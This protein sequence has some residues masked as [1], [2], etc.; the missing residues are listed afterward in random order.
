MYTFKNKSLLKL[1]L[2]R[3]SYA[4]EKGV[5][6]NERLEFLGDS[7]LGYVI[8][9]NLFDYGYDE[10]GM[11]QV[12]KSIVC[13]KNLVKAFDRL[14][15]NN[16]IMKKLLVG[17]AD[18]N[19]DYMNNDKIKEDTFEAII[20]AIALDCNYDYDILNEF[21]SRSVKPNYI[22]EVKHDYSDIISEYKH[23]VCSNNAC[24]LL[25]ELKQKGVINAFDY[26]MFI[27]K[28]DHNGNPIWSG[29]LMIEYDNKIITVKETNQDSKKFLKQLLSLSGIMSL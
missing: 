22:Y 4:N 23:N 1:A 28:Y 12:R 18:Y 25:Q 20:G 2:T 3:S 16:V 6:S 24:N 14:N 29:E 17:N 19:N 8:T 11:T 26:N 10:D 7:V 5:E 9:R 27:D 13:G 21:I 15:V